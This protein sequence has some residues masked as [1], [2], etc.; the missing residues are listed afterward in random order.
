MYIN[1]VLVENYNQKPN[2][3]ILCV[4]IDVHSAQWFLF[5]Y[6]CSVTTNFWIKKTWYTLFS[7]FIKHYKRKKFYLIDCSNSI[8]FFRNTW[9]DTVQRDLEKCRHA[10]TILTAD[11]SNFKKFFNLIMNEILYFSKRDFKWYITSIIMTF[12]SEKKLNW[13]M[14][15]LSIIW[16]V[17][18]APFKKSDRAKL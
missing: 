17:S 11:E 15:N 6:W 10:S 14:E 7:T 9:C 12:Q 8:F 2:N 3:L 18:G 13:L 1:L 4:E 5:L 16:F